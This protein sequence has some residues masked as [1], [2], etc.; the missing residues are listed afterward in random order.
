MV[1]DEK[2]I[3][4]SSKRHTLICLYV[5]MNDTKDYPKWRWQAI[6]LDQGTYKENDRRKIWVY[7]ADKVIAISH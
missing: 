3:M 5:R 1:D 2:I 7:V 6:I 4:A